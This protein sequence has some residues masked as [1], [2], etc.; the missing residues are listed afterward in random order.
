[1]KAMLFGVIVFVPLMLATLPD[2]SR[3][4]LQAV[5]DALDAARLTHKDALF[6]MGVNKS[7]WSRMLTGELHLP[8]TK[9]ALLPIAFQVEFLPRYAFLV[10]KATAQEIVDDVR[11]RRS[12]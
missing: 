4:V 2:R 5:L 12:A 3:L 6:Y 10:V 8:L 1:M 7:Q 9:L 11:S